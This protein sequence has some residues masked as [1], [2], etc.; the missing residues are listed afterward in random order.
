MFQRSISRRTMLRGAGVALAL[1]L[2]ESMCPSLAN[3]KAAEQTKSPQRFVA[4]N[5]PLGFHPTDFFPKESGRDYALSPYLEVAKDL[6]DEFTV[7]SGLSHPDV[8]G[9]HSA[10][11]SFLTAAPHPGAP[12][13]TNTISLDQFLAK[14]IGDQTRFASLTLGSHSLSWSANGVVIPTETSP[15]KLFSALFLKGS[16]KDLAQQ[17]AQLQ[18][19]Q[20]IMDAVLADARAMQPRI[21]TTDRA[22]LD[23]Y[24]T[25]VRETEQRLAKSQAWLNKPKPQ[26]EEKP[27]AVI[28]WMDFTGNFRSFLDVVRLA[29]QT[30]S[31]RVV[32]FGGDAGS[33]V[34]P[35][36]G[37]SQ[38]YH[39]L[40]HHGLDTTLIE[41]LRII[42][43]ETIK[44]W[45]DF[46]TA[47]RS[48]PDGDSNL[49]RNT[50]V[51]FGSN[52][53]NA[54]SHSTTNL[55]IIHAGGRFKHGQHLA[56]DAK[57]NSPL[58]K[59]FVSI[60][61]GCGQEVDRFASGSGTIAGLEQA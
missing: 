5:I 58:A 61:Q 60:L 52:L 48:T 7:F 4:I 34:S 35:L 45:A 29:I 46:L 33:P 10:E 53:G 17:Q 13:F 12:S 40:S 42:D 23:Q 30:D 32:A 57:Q 8:D 14:R 21:S 37:I 56:F 47:L 31:T 43:R 18:D 3:A 49:L 41:E 6:R 44:I 59:L 24:F 51:L 55:P 2:L 16:E 20:S 38:A 39:T 1:P 15:T 36:K 50:Q 9:G 19:G 26:I 27:P 28:P 22:K 54:N 11:K 25:A